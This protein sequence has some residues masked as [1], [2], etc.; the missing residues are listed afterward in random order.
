MNATK[1]RR[2]K[3]IGIAPR[4]DESLHPRE[5][6]G[7]GRWRRGGADGGGNEGERDRKGEGHGGCFS[8]RGEER[9]ARAFGTVTK[10]AA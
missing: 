4:A 10:Q 9:K 5:G 7:G 2:L 8:D 1:R 3:P 6:S